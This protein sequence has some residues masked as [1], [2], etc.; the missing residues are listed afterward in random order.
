VSDA[1]L[2]RPFPLRVLGVSHRTAATEIREGLAFSPDEAMD[3]LARGRRDGAWEEALLLST[4]NRTELYVAEEEGHGRESLRSRLLLARPALPTGLPG[5]LFEEAGSGAA[6]RMLRVAC[7]LESLI[8]GEHEIVGQVREA[9][10]L[11]REAGTSGPR[12]DPVVQAALRLAVRARQVTGISRGVS[13]VPGAALAVA[14]RF[15][16]R[17]KDRRVLV[18][19]AGEAGA[20]TARLIAAQHPAALWVTN[21]SPERAEALAA[22]L[23]AATWSFDDLGSALGE[24]DLV[25]SAV[26]APEPVVRMEHLRASAKRRAGRMLLLVDIAVPR[27]IDPRAGDLE[28]VFLQ[29][30]DALESL[31]G[32]HRAAR[33]AEVARVEELI[34]EGVTRLAAAVE[35]RRAEPLVAA[36]RRDLEVLR[37]RELERSLRHFSPEQREALERLTRSL[38]DKAFHHP[39]T[40]LRE[41]GPE[42]DGDLVRRLFGLHVESLEGAQGC[43]ALAEERADVDADDS[44]DEPPAKGA[45]VPRSA[46]GDEVDRSAEGEK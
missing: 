9:H 22:E 27:S 34:D 43:P 40:A 39:M 26:R 21:R 2:V 8:L 37:R 32:V 28:G 30:M 10:R 44:A 45:L 38:L 42:A 14:K 16:D 12:L 6:R 19:G 24:V 41:L 4:C 17:L 11:S 46:K 25:I 3:F 23:R 20:L 7:G 36:L 29:D 1:G 18:I 15:F 13:G 31:M 33:S 5:A 35:R